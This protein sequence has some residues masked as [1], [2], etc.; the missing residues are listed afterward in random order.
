MSSAA[1]AD[2][3][4][5]FGR[6]WLERGQAGQAAPHLERAIALRPEHAETHR[7][8]AYLRLHQERFAEAARHL[9]IALADEPLDSPQHEKTALL[10]QLAG[11]PP[12]PLDLPDIPGGRL[13][14]V[15]RRDWSHHRSGWGYAWRA[16]SGLHHR[17]GVRCEDFLEDP[18]AWQH[19]RPGIRP[20]AELLAVLRG[21][22]PGPTS[23]ERRLVPIR[24]PW[25][26]ILH[27]PP[28]MPDGF[29]P[30]ESP[31]T[32]LD[33]PIWRGSL[34][35]CIGLFTL[36][37]YAADWLREATGKPVSAL[38]H[39][40]ETP[41]LTFDWERF[42]ANPHKRVIQ[43]G[44]WLRRLSA[45]DRLPIPCD[46]PLCL[47]KLRL[48]PSFF[49]GADDYLTGLHA[50]ECT[51]DGAPE[52]AH[53]ANTEVRQH[54]PNAE[55]DRLLAENIGF[56]SLY[57]ASA[58]NAVIE[59]LVRATPLLV[60]PLPAVREYLGDG[61][62]LYYDDLDAAAALAQDISRLRAAHDWLRERRA[63]Y[64]L[65]ADA[66]RRAVVGS[67]VYQSLSTG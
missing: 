37:E 25:V 9:E 13:R 1:E 15:R 48:M 65:D 66:F 21:K 12:A 36:S 6:V 28:N 20:G 44:W 19:P 16:L 23:E 56:V 22:A 53:A 7:W 52:P 54:V 61:Y 59:C 39:P 46:N 29:H 41:A 34:P 57:D 2:A 18:F 58:N 45:I 32:I 64:P 11:E 63:A 62:P 4:L 26:G 40:T 43:I 24:E 3:A 33:K 5:L 10:R 67:E 38:P 50:A 31:R 42:L 49:D 35:A 51:R 47:G 14:L 60:N 17:G 30:Q 55:F 27:N 8:V